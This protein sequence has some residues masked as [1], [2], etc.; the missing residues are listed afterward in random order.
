MVSATIKERPRRAGKRVSY[1]VQVRGKGFPYSSATFD[2]KGAAEA[3]ANEVNLA[4]RLL[5]RVHAASKKS[6]STGGPDREFTIQKEALSAHI[7]DLQHRKGS[8]PLW[9]KGASSGNRPLGEGG[10]LEEAMTVGD[11]VREFRDTKGAHL[12]PSEATSLNVIEEDLGK[13]VYIALQR[14]NLDEFIKN[15]SLRRKATRRSQP[16]SSDVPARATLLL[17]LIYLERVFRWAH[18]ILGLKDQS[19]LVADVREQAQSEGIVGPSS[20]AGRALSR[21]QIQELCAEIGARADADIRLR[22]ASLLQ[23]TGIF[24]PGEISKIIG[25]HV[26]LPDRVV[27]LPSR[28]NPKAKIDA[29]VPLVPVFDI[30]P[31]EIIADQIRDDRNSG[32]YDGT[33]PLF[34]YTTEELRVF[35]YEVSAARHLAS[36]VPYDLRHTG[37]RELCHIC[38]GDV[39]LV[40]KITGHRDLKTLAFYLRVSA[41]AAINRYE[42][43]CSC[44]LPRYSETGR[45]DDIRATEPLD[46]Q[47]VQIGH[48]PLDKRVEIAVTA[49]WSKC[50]AKAKD[51][52]G[53]AKMK[54]LKKSGFFDPIP[55]LA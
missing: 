53:P 43:Y 6:A 51:L 29:E 18:S 12:K 48:L 41:R 10:P 30:D 47:T 37:V 33:Q 17:D 5:S 9:F 26:R 21:P 19:Q 44:S 50:E 15:R 39:F 40:Q 52:I 36:F 49:N 2:D 38:N 46:L 7:R 23:H 31:A 32:T 13:V 22:R 4:D 54:S 28:K 25:D 16:A 11:L 14:I 42:N 1:R 8:A 34:P 27:V 24:R 45:R 20:S 3:Y 55:G 35:F